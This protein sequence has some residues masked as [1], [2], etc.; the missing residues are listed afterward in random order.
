MQFYSPLPVTL[1]HATD[2]RRSKRSRWR[3]SEVFPGIAYGDPG[4]SGTL[5]TRISRRLR[6]DTRAVMCGY[7]GRW[8]DTESRKGQ[9]SYFASFPFAEKSWL[10]VVAPVGINLVRTSSWTSVN[11]CSA[12]ARSTETTKRTEKYI[13]DIFAQLISNMSEDCFY[14]AAEQ[15]NVSK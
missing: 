7:C 14:R 6:C 1:C 10:S 2:V 12:F 13:S 3:F 5:F 9:I 15:L 4:V 8:C 11:G